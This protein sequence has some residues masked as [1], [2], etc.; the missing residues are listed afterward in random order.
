MRYRVRRHSYRHRIKPGA[1]LVGDNI[2]LRQYHRQR[3]GP[4][5]LGESAG[6]LIKIFDEPQYVISLR[7]M[8]YQRI[9]LRATLGNK[10]IFNGV[11]VERVRRKTVDSLRG[12]GDKLARF[13]QT[14][15][16]VKTLLAVFFGYQP[17][18]H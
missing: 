15:R 18:Y 1:D 10:N 8:H 4:I 11:S 2:A 17:C 3:P 5:C 7:N 13:E 14:R 12:Y 9:V 6:A 16:L